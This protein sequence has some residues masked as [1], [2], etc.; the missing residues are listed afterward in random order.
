MSDPLIA[1]A[2]AGE[3]IEDLIA[4]VL[5]GYEDSKIWLGTLHDGS[6]PIQVHLTVTRNQDDF[7]DE[8]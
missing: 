7:L 1:A 3:H 6:T 4:D 5:S 8:Q 2:K